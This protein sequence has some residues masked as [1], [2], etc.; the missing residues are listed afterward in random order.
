MNSPPEWDFSIVAASG[1]TQKEFAALVRVSR[2]S[3]IHWMQGRCKPSRHVAP[4]L[5]EILKRVREAV[6][7]GTLPPPTAVVRHGID[8]ERV[9]QRMKEIVHALRR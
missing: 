2:I 5:T 3:V 7:S 4:R 6:D 8:P 9:A 1:L